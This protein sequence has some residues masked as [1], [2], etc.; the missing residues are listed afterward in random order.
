M[1]YLVHLSFIFFLHGCQG[2]KPEILESIELKNNL[3]TLTFSVPQQ[4]D[5]FYTWTHHSDNSCDHYE[6]FRF[7]DKEYSLLM[8][9]GLFS[10]IAFDSILQITIS[11][12]KDPG[13]AN[14]NVK[15]N[16]TYLE[17][18]SQEIKSLT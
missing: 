10:Q 8:E 17:S 6:K 15:I 14:R 2:S 7:A 13:C 4:L 5:T 3:G 1:K 9:S 16:N 12:L 18:Q 11:Q